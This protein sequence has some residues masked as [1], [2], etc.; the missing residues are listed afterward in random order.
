MFAKLGSAPVHRPIR[1]T[2]VAL[3]VSV[4]FSTAWVAT[5][6]PA[7]AQE[8]AFQ[9]VVVEGNALVD[10]ATIIKF[11]GIARGETVT[12]AGLNDAYQ[13]I[14]NSGLFETVELVP[15]G[16]TLI[17][18]VT[19]YPTINVVDF[20]GNRRLK[21]EDLAPLVKSQAR[22]VFSPS[23]VEADAAAIAEAYGEAGRLAARVEPRVIRRDGNK[24][25]LVFE[26]RE[27][28]VT[29]V[30]RLSFTGNRSFSDRRL[31]QALE[32]KQA[33]LLRTFIQRDS[34]V[35]DRVE[36]DKQLLTDFYR[37]RGFIDFQVLGVASEF[38]RDREGFFLTFNVQEGQRYKFG[39]VTTVSEYE[40]VDAAKFDAQVRIRSGAYYSPTAIDTTIARM[41]GV[42][43]REGLTFLAVEPRFIRNEQTGVLDVEFVLT[44]GPRVFVERIDIEGNATTLD[45]VIRRQFRT[46]EGDPLNPR[47]IRQAAERIRALGFFSNAEVTANA[48]SSEDQVIVD[49]NVEEQPT[50]SLGFGINYGAVQGVGFNISFSESNF[51]GRGQFLGVN[52]NSGLDNANSSIS[53][54]EPALFNRDLKLKFNAVYAT[55][56]NDAEFYS[57]RTVSVSP[58]LEFP[59][60]QFGRLEVRYLIA[61][62]D[63]FD[64][65]PTAPGPGSALLAGEAAQGALVTSALGYS[66]SYDTRIGGLNPNRGFL[67]R[68][69]QDYAGLG[70]DVNSVTTT[71]L[72]RAETKAFNEE[73]TF[74]AEIEGGAINMLSGESR[75]IDRYFGNGKI[76]GFEPNGIGPRDLA[77][78]DQDAV[79]GNFFAVARLEAE[80]PIGLP[81]EYGIRGGVFADAGSVWGLDN[82]LGGAIDDSLHLRSTIGV[83]LFWDTPIG[84]LRFNFSKALQKEPYDL[85]RTFDFTVSTKF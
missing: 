73:V 34:F 40:G 85:E 58:A 8:Y 55:S 70:G 18:R 82:D 33:G 25:D 38:V 16:G 29:E 56:E 26:I 75:A 6:G 62:N 13:R 50:G 71:L 80:F 81:E 76:R 63:M 1:S 36:L 51:L 74:R 46:V 72:A 35:G 48:G 68:F 2:F 39:R 43:Q 12:A 37:S 53:F 84:P 32:T 5:P 44:K 7:L 28:K 3:L 78:I 45:Q 31:R 65:S 23:T 10:A 66:Y 52:L 27:G 79:G 67:L 64:Y 11:A 54:V 77:A 59:V 21:D 14:V 41:E 47:E 24:V 20:E 69:G 57:T 30:E 4:A 42:A 9:E 60:S 61:S 83:S 22:R 19:E 15:S 49:V 17:I